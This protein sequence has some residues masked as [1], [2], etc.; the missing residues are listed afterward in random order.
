MNTDQERKYDAVDGK[1]VNRAT[2][3]P[4]P[5]DEPIFI[6][7]AKD[8][9]SLVALVAYSNMCSD[10]LHRKVILGRL[11]DFIAWQEANLDKVKEPDSDPSCLKS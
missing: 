11:Q 5:D 7:R 3:K 9:I 8:Q 6:F 1:I 2:G 10:D 4:I